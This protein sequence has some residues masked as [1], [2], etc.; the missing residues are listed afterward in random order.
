MFVIHVNQISL[1][2]TF[3]KMAVVVFQH[4]SGTF[5]IIQ[6]TF[7]Q[8]PMVNVSMESGTGQLIF[9]P[10][11]FGNS[12]PPRRRLKWRRLEERI[13]AL[14]V[15]HRNGE[16]FGVF[17]SDLSHYLFQERI[18]FGKQNPIGKFCYI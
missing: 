17:G 15:Q 13:V 6:W 1:L 14:K 9:D 7:E 18:G 2:L 5:T 3:I 12:P 8:I 4:H 10:L 16:K 11:Q